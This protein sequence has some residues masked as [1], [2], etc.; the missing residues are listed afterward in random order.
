MDFSIKNIGILD[1]KLAL[2]SEE[3]KSA[4]FLIKNYQAKMSKALEKDLP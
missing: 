3:T 4:M 1:K 2:V